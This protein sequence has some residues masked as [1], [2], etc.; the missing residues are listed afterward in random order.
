MTG[1]AITQMGIEMLVSMLDARYYD[2]GMISRYNGHL[3]KFCTDIMHFIIAHYAFTSRNDTA[4]WRAVNQETELPPELEA[5][6]DVFRQKHLPTSSTKGTLEVWMFRDISWFSVLLGMNFDFNTPI[7]EPE[8][9]DRAQRI[10]GCDS[11]S[12][13]RDVGEATQP[14]R[15]SAGSSLRLLIR[16]LPRSWTYSSQP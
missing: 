10:P 13:C 11:P 8:A 9:L 16:D 14:L 4:F 1:L 5:R 7:I 12:G 6:L 15:L 2:S 3:E